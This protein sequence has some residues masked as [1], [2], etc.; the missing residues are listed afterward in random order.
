MSF[1]IMECHQ[2]GAIAIGTLRKHVAIDLRVEMETRGEGIAPTGVYCDVCRRGEL[3]ALEEIWDDPAYNLNT[4]A[5]GVPDYQRMVCPKCWQWY[6]LKEKRAAGIRPRC[7]HC[8][9]DVFLVP[10]VNP[11]PKMIACPSAGQIPA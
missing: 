9:G 3:W 7:T 6:L 2:C 10:E 5:Y 1:W 4:D 8:E 11:L